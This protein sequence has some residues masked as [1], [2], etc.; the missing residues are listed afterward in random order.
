MG[1]LRR[2]EFHQAQRTFHV[3]CCP[4]LLL[5][6]QDSSLLLLLLLKSLDLLVFYCFDTFY[7]QLTRVGAFCFLFLQVMEGGR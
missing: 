1:W 2:R 7:V 4:S 6:T 5:L 3:S